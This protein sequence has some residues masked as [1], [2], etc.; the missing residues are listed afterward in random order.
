MAE[1]CGRSLPDLTTSQQQKK[2][3]KDFASHA[4]GAWFGQKSP[5]WQAELFVRAWSAL[6]QQGINQDSKGKREN[7][8][9]HC[10]R[11]TCQK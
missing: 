2:I 3:E 8:A 9:L 10:S 1:L 4:A 5:R 11:V 7:E 6:I